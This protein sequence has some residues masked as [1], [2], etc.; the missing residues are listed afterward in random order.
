MTQFIRSRIVNLT[1]ALTTRIQR[2]LGLLPA[3]PPQ[4]LDLSLFPE[5]PLSNQTESQRL[6]RFSR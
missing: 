4:Q 2:Y 6:S 1:V 5:A 3:T